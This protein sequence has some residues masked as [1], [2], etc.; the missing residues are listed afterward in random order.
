MRR[1]SRIRP[2]LFLRQSRWGFAML[3][4]WFA[5]GTIAFHH[6]EHRPLSN[7]FLSAVYF[8]FHPGSLSALYSFWGPMRLV[9]NHHF[10][11]HSSSAATLQSAG[12]VPHARQ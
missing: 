3:A 6:L 7:A 11:L 12:A 1:F 9:R 4:L 2:A 8:H 10:H 5:L